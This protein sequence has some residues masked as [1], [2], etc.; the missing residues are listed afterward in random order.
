MRLQL[1]KDRTEYSGQ[2][3][4]PQN[5]DAGGVVLRWQVVHRRTRRYR[6]LQTILSTP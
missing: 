2:D 1:T 6:Y 4:L 3:P 5:L